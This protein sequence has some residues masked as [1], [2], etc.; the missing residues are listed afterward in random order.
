MGY[1][2]SKIGIKI[3]PKKILV[4]KDSLVPKSISDIRSFQDLE[5]FYRRFIKGLSTIVAPL[6]ECFKVSVFHWSSDQY[7]SFAII[8]VALIEA[9]VLPLQDFDKPFQIDVEALSIG[10]GVV[11]IQDVHPIEFFS[12]KLSTTRQKWTIYEQQHYTV[13]HTLKHR[14]HCLL[15]QDFVLCSNHQALQ[16]IIS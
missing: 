9:H 15:H 2:I 6:M 4:I 3:D 13:I 7:A 12:E 16:Y 10:I 1:I 5:N 14:E 11:L 8:K